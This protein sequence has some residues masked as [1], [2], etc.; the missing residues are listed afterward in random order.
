MPQP[1]KLRTAAGASL[2]RRLIG[3]FVLPLGPGVYAAIMFAVGDLRAE[4]I[5]IAI[6]A[7]GF[8]YASRWTKSVLFALAPGLLIV[9]GY[10]LMRYIRPIFVVPSRVIGCAAR[11]LDLTFFGIG[12]NTT[13]SDYFA[14]HHLIALDLFF[15]IPYSVFFIITIVYCVY[16]FVRDRARLDRYLWSLALL[17]AMAFVVWLAMPVA[18]PWY[19]RD[20]GCAIVA[21]VIP[22]PAGLL[23]VDQ[24]FGSHY[25]AGFYSRAPDV[26]GA[27]PSLHCA[28]PAIGLF[29]AWRAATWTTWPLHLVYLFSMFA[30]SIYLGHHWV[31]DGLTGWLMALVAVLI[32]SAIMRAR[33]SRAAAP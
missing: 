7:L 33:T 29:T 21:G 26:F 9:L 27:I 20:H 18:P 5:A 15:A 8:G 17:H 4:H 16:L 3:D 6:F 11:D 13:L 12:P 19:I 22:S 25:F 1:R 28:F 24:F 32:V 10:D 23:R 14:A 31:V 30:A 2:T